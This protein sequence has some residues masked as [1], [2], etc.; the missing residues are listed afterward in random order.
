M[1]MRVLLLAAIAVMMAPLAMANKEEVSDR[2][3]KKATA[4][5]D[6]VKN[7][8][9]SADQRNDE[10]I[11]TI[12]PLFDFALMARLSLGKKHWNALGKTKQAEFTKLYVKRMKNSYSQKID[13]YTDEKIVVRSV[14]QP[15]KSRIVLVTDLVGASD[16]TEVVYKYHKLKKKLP[17]KDAWLVYDAVI[18]GVSIITTDKSQFKEVLRENSIDFLMDKMRQNQE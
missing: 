6:I 3:M 14:K 17:G 15:K 11:K 1:K 4:V 12:D 8:K 2:F 18:S 5:V 9:L 16:K 7:K 13:N 10:I